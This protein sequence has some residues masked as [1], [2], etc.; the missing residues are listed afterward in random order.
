[1]CGIFGYI[2]NK[3]NAAELVLEGLKTLE[4]RGYD[5][6]GIAVIKNVITHQLGRTPD[7]KIVIRKKAGKIGNAT[8]SDF[9][10][11]HFA[12]GHTRWA[13]HGGVTDK[14]AHPHFDCSNTLAIVHNGI[15]ENYE[16]IK[17]ELI[18]KNHNFISETDSEVI[19]H[20]IEEYNREVTFKEAVRKSFLRLRGR[21]AIIVMSAKDNSMIVVK[22]GSPIVIGIGE[23]ENFIASDASALLTHTKKV[24]YLEDDHLALINDT[25]IIISSVENDKTIKNKIIT[26]D[27]KVEEAEKAPYPHFLLKEIMEQ[28]QTIKSAITQN[29]INIERFADLMKKSFG[30]YFVGCGSAA[31]ACREA[32]YIF[33]MIAHRHINFCVGSEFAYFKDFLTPKSLLIAVSQSGETADILE[34]VSAAKTQ[35]SKINSIVNVMG[36][37]LS[38]ISDVCLPLRVG[39]EK[40]VLSTKAFTAKLALFYLLAYTMDN[41]YEYGYKELLNTSNVISQL[42]NDNNF[43]QNILQ[44]VDKIYR[45]NDLYIIGRGLSYP[46]ALEAAHKIKEASYIHAEGFAGGEPKHCEIALITDGTPCIIFAPEDETH[47]A[48]LSNAMEFKSRGGYIIGISPNREKVFDEWIKVP[49]IGAISSIVNVIPAQL[50]AYY[51]AVRRGCDPDKPRNLAKSVTVK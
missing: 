11:S 21:N 37:T 6:W 32:T 41:K 28:G 47:Q 29:R 1:M 26:L 48:I 40:S 9:P 19:V 34:A 18:S 10:R 43:H 27:W 35:K 5:S 17:E 33:S 23:K 12:L 49:D 38:R 14:N 8:V 4:Y 15:V 36:S 44:I 51:L 7:S 46:V 45:V 50:M 31:H 30:S 3:Q 2:G 20:L 22:N 13:T 16:E 39:P 24:I 42:L 25:E